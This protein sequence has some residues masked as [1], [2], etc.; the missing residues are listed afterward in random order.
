[1]SYKSI[2]IASF[3]IS[4]TLSANTA[5]EIKDLKE[6]VAALEENRGKGESVPYAA[7]PEAKN[8]VGLFMTVEP[9]YWKAS[10]KGLTYAIKGDNN[11]L[12]GIQIDLD[13]GKSKK[14]DFDWSWGVRLGLGYD[15][16]RDGWDLYT[17]WTHLKTSDHSSASIAQSD[18]QAAPGEYLSP[19]WIAQ[20]FPVNLPGLVNS[21]SAHWK[22]N[23][24]LIDFELGREFF[25]SKWLTLRPFIGG[26]VAWINQDY[27]LKFARNASTVAPIYPAGNTSQWWLNMDNDFWGIGIRL[28]L[29]TKWVLGKGFSVY[30]DGAFSILD[31]HFHNSFKQRAKGFGVISANSKI[32]VSTTDRFKNKNHVHSDIATIDLNLGLRWESTFAN[33][34]GFFAL[35]TGYE[36]HVFFEQNQFM[37]YQYDFTL[38]AGAIEGPS[39]YT[40]GSSLTTH[41]LV[42]GAEFGF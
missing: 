28:G 23:L 4:Q 10:E 6:R 25:I 16:Q 35:W 7:R 36:Q 42:L 18:P 40:N 37:N 19:F 9:I 11:T 13:H 27:N 5:Y 1:M 20:L 38:L 26:R 39:F 22:L 34:K 32:P 29:D 24:E 2:L 12:L 17:S 41:G 14:P 33:D 3:G 31:G 8:S 15:F 21:A 30:G